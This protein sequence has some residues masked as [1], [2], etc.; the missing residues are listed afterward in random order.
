M[1]L[2]LSVPRSRRRSLFEAAALA[3][4][5]VRRAVARF[6]R[7]CYTIRRSVAMGGKK[8]VAESDRDSKIN[9]CAL[10]MVYR[11]RGISYPFAERSFS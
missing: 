2:L 4:L 3:V 5:A 1:R 10:Q 7:L 11:S 6:V 8:P 9:F